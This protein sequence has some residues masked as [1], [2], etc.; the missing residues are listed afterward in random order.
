M[1]QEKAG[2][3]ERGW[4]RK[5]I[6]KERRKSSCRRDEAVCEECKETMEWEG[7]KSGREVYIVR[8]ARMRSSFPLL[9]PGPPRFFGGMKNS[10]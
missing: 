10:E 4:R 3:Q 1:G 2:I 9:E 6:A 5:W 7:G 8:P